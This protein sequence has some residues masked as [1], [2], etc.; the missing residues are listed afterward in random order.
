MRNSGIT[1]RSVATVTACPVYFTATA[2]HCSAITHKVCTL[3]IPMRTCPRLHSC[4]DS[5]SFVLACTHALTAV[6]LSS[7]ALML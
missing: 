2:T 1:H 3:C 5:R 4:S 7:L 6:L